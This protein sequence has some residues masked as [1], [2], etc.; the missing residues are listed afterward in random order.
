MPKQLNTI[1]QLRRDNDYN[2]AKIADKFIP[3][4]GEICLVDT[5]RSGLRAVCGDGKTPFAQLEYT[6]S[7]YIQG[8]FK[9]NIFYQDEL[10]TLPIAANTKL[11]YVDLLTNSLYFYTG[12]KYQEF[13]RAHSFSCFSK[14][15]CT[16]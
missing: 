9:D 2:Y 10:F 14:I 8:Y 13:S 12:V 16:F 6:D 4:K 7:V 1:L 15:S 5:A 11:L 3:A